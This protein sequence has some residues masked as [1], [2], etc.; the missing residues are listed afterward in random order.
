M[1]VRGEE[2]CAI[3][4]DEN[5]K[6][7]IRA[8]WIRLL[9]K[10]GSEQE[11]LEIKAEGQPFYLRLM[12][13]LLAFAGDVD[14]EFLL[15]GEV[16][17][18]VGVLT[19]LPRTPHVYEEQTSW[20]LEEE[21]LMREEVWRSNHQSV[22]LHTDFVYSHFDEE[23]E[24]GL[25]EKLTMEQA[26][27]NTV[28]PSSIISCSPGGREPSREA[29]NN[30]RRNAWHLGQQQDQMQ[31]QSQKSQCQGEAVPVGAFQESKPFSLQS[32]RGHKQSAP[33]ISSCAM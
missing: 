25:M 11:G 19:P 29:S 1:A 23:C 32:R 8:L 27:E 17:F 10:H 31:G 7:K 6:A 9:R 26:K 13:E 16:G 33:E 20:R 21:P 18:P 22:D 12:K 24:E 4:C 30:T 28:T 5:L 14:R 15:E 2:G 3:V